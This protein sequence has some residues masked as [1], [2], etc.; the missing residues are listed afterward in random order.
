MGYHYY[1]TLNQ[2]KLICLNKLGAV[3]VAVVNQM[4][5]CKY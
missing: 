1:L 5:T 2:S 4:K 3:V